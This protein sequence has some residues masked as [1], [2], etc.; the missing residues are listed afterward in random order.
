[1]SS[2]GKNTLGYGKTKEAIHEAYAKGMTLLEAAKHYGLTY[3]SAYGGA[4]RSGL[5]FKRHNNRA[6]YGHTK[7]M[8]IYESQSGLTMAQIARKHGLNYNSV[9]SI[10]K[11]C[12]L[13]I[14]YTRKTNE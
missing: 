3:A 10:N 11:N 2:S 1:V 14:P 12:Q 6:L 9:R 8:V 4:K 5:V 13:N 7:L